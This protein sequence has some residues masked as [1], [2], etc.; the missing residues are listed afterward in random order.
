MRSGVEPRWD[1]HTWER[2]CSCITTDSM[3]M[4]AL[5]LLLM[6]MMKQTGVARLRINNQLAV[7]SFQNLI[8]FISARHHHHYDDNY[9]DFLQ[10]LQ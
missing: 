10:K 3:I 1:S 6:M 8:R 4:M 9:Y 7:D 2:G 5:L